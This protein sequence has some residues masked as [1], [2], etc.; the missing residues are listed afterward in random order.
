M[1]IDQALVRLS[2]ERKDRLLT[3]LAS[4]RVLYRR[5]DTLTLWGIPY[6]MRE[7]QSP[8]D[9]WKGTPFPLPGHY[10]T[11]GRCAGPREDWINLGAPGW[12][13]GSASD[14]PHITSWLQGLKD[15][16][17]EGPEEWCELPDPQTHAPTVLIR[18]DTATFD[19]DPDIR[20]RLRRHKK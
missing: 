12:Y 13:P 18:V 4:I 7:G 10:G 1:T 17:P 15:Y 2:E 8:R 9:L 16:V 11:P 14:L 19:N 3:A 6:P 5:S 20:C